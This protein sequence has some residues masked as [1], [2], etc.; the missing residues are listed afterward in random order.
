M[1]PLKNPRVASRRVG[2]EAVAISPDDST[3]H[4][5]NETAARVWDL[6]DG[7]TPLEEIARRLTL[8]FDIDETSAVEDVE[9]IC[10]R[11]Q[12]LNLI[13]LSPDPIEG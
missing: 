3:L 12:K 2:L 8:E 10:Q 13:V 6:S 5:F 1:Y 4:T 11:L 9:I 7:R